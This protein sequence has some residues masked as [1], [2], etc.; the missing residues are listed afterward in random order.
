MTGRIFC[1]RLLPD[2]EIHQTWYAGE[3]IR[4]TKV[5]TSVICGKSC[6]PSAAEIVWSLSGGSGLNC[7]WMIYDDAAGDSGDGPLFFAMWDVLSL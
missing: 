2:A 6:A 1:G 4:L 3:S 7:I 5:S